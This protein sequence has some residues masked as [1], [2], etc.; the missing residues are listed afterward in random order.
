MSVETQLG[1]DG[2]VWTHKKADDGSIAG[3][4][5]MEWTRAVASGDDNTPEQWR[6]TP[7]IPFENPPTFLLRRWAV[8]PRR[9]IQVYTQRYGSVDGAQEG[10]AIAEGIAKVTPSRGQTV[11]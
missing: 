8:Q 6:I 2:Q 10:A 3:R 1:A 9:L 4:G 7:T 5:G 11:D